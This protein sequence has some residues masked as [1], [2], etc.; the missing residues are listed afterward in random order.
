MTLF[1]IVISLVAVW[2]GTL[3]I[4]SLLAGWWR[5]AQAYRNHAPFHGR[6][7]HLQFMALKAKCGYGLVTF[8]ANQRGLYISVPLGRFQGHPSLFIPWE[9]IS[10]IP[11]DPPVMKV[12]ACELNFKQVDGVPIRIFRKLY[13]R[14][15][16]EREGRS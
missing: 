15:I 9:D 3:W 13:E 7:W 10:F 6:K 12:Y 8:G 14:L 2:C 1:F 4:V 5:L 16:E 11:L